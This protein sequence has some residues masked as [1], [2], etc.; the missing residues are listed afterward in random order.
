MPNFMNVVISKQKIIT[1]K[2]RKAEGVFMNE[3][4]E[5]FI[6]VA[7]LI[8]NTF[9]KHCEVIIHDFSK[10]QNSV[11]FTINNNVTNR[12]VGESITPAF[13]D[14]VLLSQNF[15][16]DC[17]SNYVMTTENGKRL[18]SST[19]L[20]R[21]ANN[22]VVGALCV[23]IDTAAIENIMN[24]L[25]EVVGISQP[26]PLVKEED[27]DIS[28]IIEIVDDMIEKII[29]DKDVLRMTREEK[30]SL[31]RFMNEKGLFKIKGVVDNV[32]DRMYIS[33]VTVYSYLDEIK[34]TINSELNNIG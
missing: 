29:G 18:K 4:L 22:K 14:Q 5:K 7:N 9:G 27:E 12:K 1:T 33:K 21:D 34:K 28:N 10:P 6:P 20:L 3:A 25:A 11:V 2:V 23:N 8:G 17:S 16:D 26:V 31:I 30:I 24:Q 13:I 15:H 19:A 32:A